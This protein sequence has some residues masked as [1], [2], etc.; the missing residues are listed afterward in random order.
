MFKKLIIPCATL[1]GL[2]F[3]YRDITLHSDRDSRDSECSLSIE[4]RCGLYLVIP[5]YNSS[6]RMHL[7]LNKEALP[8]SISDYPLRILVVNSLY[9]S[10]FSDPRHLSDLLLLSK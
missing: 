10:K 1:I 3:K 9:P 4:V 5:S 2:F 6:Q 8:I 7:A